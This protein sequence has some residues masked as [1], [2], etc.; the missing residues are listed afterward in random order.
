LGRLQRHSYSATTTRCI[1]SAAGDDID[2]QLP[3][4][5]T[6]AILLDA[7]A[8]DLILTHP[9]GRVRPTVGESGKVT[10]STFQSSPT[11]RGGCDPWA[12]RR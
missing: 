5:D 1:L 2:T 8:G 3:S 6:Y 10:V 11:P 4:S 12:G 7:D 9:E